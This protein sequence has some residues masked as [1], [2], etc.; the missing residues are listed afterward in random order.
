MEDSSR[1]V[2]NRR[3]A[4]EFDELGTGSK[5][6]LQMPATVR[7]RSRFFRRGR[8]RFREAWLH[9]TY[10]LFAFENHSL[11]FLYSITLYH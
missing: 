6:L 1:R 9:A 3:Y 7:N 4:N 2:R 8:Y 11:E 5:C 10:F